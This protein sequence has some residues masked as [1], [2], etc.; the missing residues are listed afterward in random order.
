MRL[1]DQFVASAAR[2]SKRGLVGGQKHRGWQLARAAA[3]AGTDVVDQPVQIEGEV[4][5]AGDRQAASFRSSKAC[6]MPSIITRLGLFRPA[7]KGPRVRC[8]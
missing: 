5:K 6:A 1:G 7:T 8:R 3:F 2:H 4:L